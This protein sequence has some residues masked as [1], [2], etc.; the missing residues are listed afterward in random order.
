[1]LITA[2]ARVQNQASLVYVIAVYMPYVQPLQAVTVRH[3]RRRGDTDEGD[4]AA[5]QQ[6]APLVFVFATSH[7]KSLT[8]LRRFQESLLGSAIFCFV[9][10]CCCFF[11]CH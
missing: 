2:L 9:V 1:M 5:T 6:S 3:A 10:F 11:C 8:V 4:G 7:T